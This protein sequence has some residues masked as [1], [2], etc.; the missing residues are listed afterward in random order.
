MDSTEDKVVEWL[1]FGFAMK[2]GSVKNLHTYICIQNIWRNTSILILSAGYT[3]SNNMRVLKLIMISIVE[4]NA[5]N[6][7][8][9]ARLTF[10]KRLDESGGSEWTTQ[11]S[12]L[13]WIRTTEEQINMKK[14]RW[15]KR[16][17][18]L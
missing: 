7:L 4:K 15:V 8:T 1:I 18:E 11:E 10:G 3:Y 9:E 13:E 16:I 14:E 2:G 12:L 17:E 6:Q 5:E